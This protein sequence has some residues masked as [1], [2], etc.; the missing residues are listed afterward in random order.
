[1]I[2]AAPKTEEIPAVDA[3]ARGIEVMIMAADTLLL[4]G[5][6]SLTGR[7]AQQGRLAAAGLYQAVQDVRNRGGVRMAHRHLVP[8]VVILDDGSTREG[9]RRSLDRVS[10][11]DLLVGPYGSDLVAEAAR[12]AADGGRTLWNH[13]GNADD[14]QRL[15]GVVSVGT[16]ASRYLSSV[17]DAVATGLPEAR[18]MVAVGRGAFGRSVAHGAREAAERLGMTI[19]G[20][21]PR[22]SAGG[23]ERRRVA[24]GRYL[25]GGPRARPSPAR[26]T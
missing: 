1:M 8:D 9:V 3:Y 13:G 23:T 22:R 20:I 18:V 10:G 17:L 11:A 4:A 25:R 15:P 2:E 14:V 12:W 7:Y 16:P 19:V 6:L 24:H 21:D 26:S 5:A